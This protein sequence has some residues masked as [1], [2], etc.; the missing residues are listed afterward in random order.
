MGKKEAE[1]GIGTKETTLVYVIV[2]LVTFFGFYL[3]YKV[4][5]WASLL[6]K[7]I[8]MGIMAVSF[9]MLLNLV[10]ELLQNLLR[11]FRLRKG[12]KAKVN[13]KVK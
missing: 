11:W 9:Y 8:G 5:G 4:T 7:V 2:T 3:G 13:S 12:Y 6:W 1:S 10:A